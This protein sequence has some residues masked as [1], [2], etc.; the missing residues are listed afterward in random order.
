M[1]AD[2]RTV[3][4][5][6]ATH[7]RLGEQTRGG[8]HMALA[9]RIRELTLSPACEALAIGATAA[10]IEQ[11]GLPLQR[12]HVAVV[13]GELPAPLRAL[14]SAHTGTL[15]QAT[16]EAAAAQGWEALRPFLPMGN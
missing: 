4:V 10:E 11:A 15:L 8:V 5:T 12:C 2:G 3:G 6:D 1:A 9:T 14:L 7:T 13:V 16:D